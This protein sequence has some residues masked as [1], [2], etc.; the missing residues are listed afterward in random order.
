ML[1]VVGRAPVLRGIGSFLVIEDPLKPAVAIAVL[2]GQVPFREMEAAKLYR[3]KWADRVVVVR[4]RQREEREA[5]LKLGIKPPEGWELSREVLLRL[6][7]PSSAILVPD[8]EA[9]GT[10]EE[11]RIVAEAIR[12]GHAA[13]ILVTSK[14]HTRRADLT[15]SYVT[16][17]KSE[18]IVRAAPQDPFDPTR[19]WTERRFILSVVREYLGLVNYWMGFPVG[20]SK[21]DGAQS[22]GQA[23]TGLQLQ[24]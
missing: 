18:G 11:L 19:W 14:Y 23:A 24:R 4:G 1:L 12:P 22:E 13:V 15:W 16:G 6:G 20:G 10:L 21:Q 5:L 3:E 7:V 8:E 9:E 17:G 2:E